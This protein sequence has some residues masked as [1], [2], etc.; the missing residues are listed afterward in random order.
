MKNFV[1][2]GDSATV[3]IS[4]VVDWDSS[5]TVSALVTQP[6]Q[7][8]QSES[9]MAATDEEASCFE[10]TDLMTDDFLAGLDG[11]AVTTIHSFA[12]DK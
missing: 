9:A 12:G 5:K 2:V 7:A 8:K 4:S 6:E 3:F 10:D 11:G 1:S